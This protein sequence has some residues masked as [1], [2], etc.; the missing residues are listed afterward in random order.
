LNPETRIITMPGG[1]RSPLFVRKQSGGMFAIESEDVTTGQRFY[2]DS[3]NTSNGADTASK[4]RNPDF[5][6]LTIDYAIGQA[7]A[8]NGDIIY[9]MPGH[10]ESITAAG[11]IT[12]D[13]IGVKIKGLGAG[14]T[15]PV[16]T[17]ASTDNSATWLIT[18][19]ECSVENIIGVCADD[20]LTSAFVVSAADVSLDI[21]WRDG[22]STIEAAQCINATADADRLDIK[23][24]YVGFIAGNACITPIYLDGLSN[25]RVDIDFYG[26]A[27]TAVVEFK[28]TAVVDVNV[29]GYMYN[30]GTTNYTKSVVDTATG[31]TWFADFFDGAAGGRVSGGSGGALAADDIGTVDSKVVSVGNQV[32][33]VDNEISTLDSKADSTATLWSTQYST[34]ISKLDSNS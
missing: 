28:D 15:R 24:K 19:A 22:S 6:F 30:S 32:T 20:G 5:P 27:S 18:A 9:V 3:G 17:W 13:V 1:T 7:G 4:G 29:T 31:S 12:Q 21:E 11:G 23:L 25:A 26:K 33:T 8:S 10:T 16:V 2:V 34:I 14:A